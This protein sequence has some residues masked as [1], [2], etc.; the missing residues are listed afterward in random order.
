VCQW[1]TP[2]WA[3]EQTTRV[4]TP[5]AIADGAW[6]P[7]QKTAVPLTRPPARGEGGKGQRDSSRA[8]GKPRRR[9][10]GGVDDVALGHGG[11]R[12]HGRNAE[13][14]WGDDSVEVAIG[15]GSYCRYDMIDYDTLSTPRVTHP[16]ELAQRDTVLDPACLVPCHLQG[17]TL[18]GRSSAPFLHQGSSLSSSVSSPSLKN[19]SKAK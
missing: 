9:E 18:R 13:G 19:R 10:A 14:R 6:P 1:Q 8:R 12:E 11:R 7:A 17:A 15:A 5:K 4:D 3:R 16:Y 2:S